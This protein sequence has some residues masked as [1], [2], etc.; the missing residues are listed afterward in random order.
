MSPSASSSRRG[1]SRLLA[2]LTAFGVLV[3]CLHAWVSP[4]PALPRA[5]AQ[6][7]NP[8]HQ[9]NQLIEELRHTNRLLSDIKRLLESGNLKVRSVS[10]DNQADETAPSEVRP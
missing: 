8:A 2:T 3:L 9:R 6:L 7:P 5:E 10:A 1:S 4:W